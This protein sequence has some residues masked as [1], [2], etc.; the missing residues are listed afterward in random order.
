MINI[1]TLIPIRPKRSA[2]QMSRGIGVYKRAGDVLGPAGVHQIR[3][4]P[5]PPCTHR[6]KPLPAR[7]RGQGSRASGEQVVRTQQ[8]RRHQDHGR[9]RIRDSQVA[10]FG[11]ILGAE[12]VGN[13]KRSAPEGGSKRN[14]HHCD[15]DEENRVTK[16]DRLEG[17]P[18][19][20]ANARR[21]RDAFH[22]VEHLAGSAYN[23]GQCA[24]WVARK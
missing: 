18:N 23:G 24:C 21:C 11:P 5:A 17:R 6:R 13:R 14:E 3:R 4:F 19:Q 10:P 7:V 8:K 12:T 1:E 22:R 20:K 15:E 16:R 9:Y 2:A